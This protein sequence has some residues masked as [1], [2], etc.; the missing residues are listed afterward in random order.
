MAGLRGASQGSDGRASFGERS[1]SACFPVVAHA[2][3]AIYSCANKVLRTTLIDRAFRLRLPLPLQL[4][5]GF[6]GAKYKSFRTNAEALE[7]ISQHANHVAATVSATGSDSYDLSATPGGSN[8]RKRLQERWSPVS[9]GAAE[10]STAWQ[11]SAEGNRAAHEGLHGIPELHPNVKQEDT[12]VEVEELHPNVK[13][14]ET[15][16]EVEELHPNVKQEET[17]KELKVEELH[18]NVKQEDT[19][20]EVEELHPNVKQEETEKELR[21]EEASPA[22]QSEPA[23][24]ASELGPV[25]PSPGA[26]LQLKQGADAGSAAPETASSGH[27]PL[28]PLHPPCLSSHRVLCCLAL[29]RSC[30]YLPCSRTSP[31]PGT[32]GRG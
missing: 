10:L 31:L 25:L 9:T 28:P 5:Q 16:V 12:E 23:D 13:Q 26:S 8:K 29:P 24:A 30:M 17:E 6:S 2:L 18:P 11:G 21:V 20:V 27:G 22:L 32:K 7:Y 1:T 4:L 19:E 15:E 14:E 3:P